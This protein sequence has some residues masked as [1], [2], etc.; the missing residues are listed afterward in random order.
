MN[1]AACLL[2]CIILTVVS[3]IRWL[4]ITQQS[5]EISKRIVRGIRFAGITRLAFSPAGVIQVAGVFVVVAVQA[6]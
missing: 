6:Q 1:M 4:F 5:L 2:S 3:I